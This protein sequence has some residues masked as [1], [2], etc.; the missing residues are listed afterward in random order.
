MPTLPR[1]LVVELGLIV[2]CIGL[3][4]GIVTW[5][6]WTRSLPPEAQLART[7]G[8][9]SWVETSRSSVRFGLKG[10]SRA[11][12]YLSKAG[13]MR[14]VA[15][16]LTPGHPGEVLVRY[17]ALDP[18][19]PPFSNRPLFNVFEIVVA[20]RNVRAYADVAKAWEDDERIAPWVGAAF[21]VCG[22]FLAAQR[23]RKWRR[24]GGIRT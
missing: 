24:P 20:G 21:V 19:T 1:A 18:H 17:D 5:A 14:E 7:S 12:Q 16:A 10:E 3:G 22:L 2:A 11:F 8:P 6:A 23:W 4:V 15:A 9:V 13:R